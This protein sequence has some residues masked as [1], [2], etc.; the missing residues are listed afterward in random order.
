MKPDGLLFLFWQFVEVAFEPN[1]V[2][3]PELRAAAGSRLPDYVEC[4]PLKPLQGSLP[5]RGIAEIR[6]FEL[7]SAIY[8]AQVRFSWIFVTYRCVLCFLVAYLA[9]SHTAI[10]KD[11]FPGS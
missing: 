9:V 3:D 2:R 11:P 5:C 8:R 10:H 1:P 4:K 6:C 7:P